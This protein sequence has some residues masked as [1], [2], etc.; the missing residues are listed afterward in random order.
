MSRSGKQKFYAIAAG[1]AVGI[2]TSWYGPGGAEEQIRGFAG[3]RF[4]GF[5]VRADAEAWLK[6]NQEGAAAAK[7]DRG[8]RPGATR[9]PARKPKRRGPTG[10]V[11]ADKAAGAGK[12]TP[13]RGD[14]VVVYTDGGAIGNPGPGG[15]GAVVLRGATRTELSGGFR[16]TTNNR[17]ELMACI[18]ALESLD[19]P[20]RVVVH[21]D[22]KYLVNAVQKGWIRRWERDRWRRPED[23]S[24]RPNTDLWQRLLPLLQFHYVEF[25]WVKGHAGSRENERCDK[26]AVTASRRRDLPVDEGY[27][28]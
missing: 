23:G 6:Q 24:D 22:S 28:R 21:S 7:G 4:K 15:Y 11:S 8:D 19:D 26:L 20:S 14:E 5:T 12:H 9:A 27:V 1:R 10:R 3:A 17:M 13:R 2:F 18:V 25:R 16:R